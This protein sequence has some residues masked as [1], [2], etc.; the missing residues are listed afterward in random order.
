[1]KDLLQFQ[2]KNVGDADVACCVLTM[3]MLSHVN[4]V[5][6]KSFDGAAEPCSV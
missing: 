1:V 3:G 6:D 5:I 2:V 4:V